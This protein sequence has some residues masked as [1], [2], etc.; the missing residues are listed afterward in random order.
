MKSDVCFLA[1]N[2]LNLCWK[3]EILLCRQDPYSQGYGFPVVMY[4]C[5]SWMVKKVEC[6]RMD[7]FKLWRWRRLLRVPWTARKIKRVNRKGNQ[8]WILIGR[9]DVEAETT[10]SWSSDANSWLIG[11][12][13]DA[14]QDWGQKGKRASKD[15][16]A[17][18][19]HWCN[20]HELGQTL[21]DGERQRGLACDSL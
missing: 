19:H 16:M 1:G 15:E 18:W 9:T 8:S 14:G 7:S 12:F 20:G 21:G 4:G 6:W 10:V 3:A 11:K 5:E 2:L 17:G 13:S